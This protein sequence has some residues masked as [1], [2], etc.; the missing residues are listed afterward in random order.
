MVVDWR[1]ISWRKRLGSGEKA[2][3]KFGLPMVLLVVIGSVG[4]SEFTDIKIKRRDEKIRK[5]NYEESQTFYVKKKKKP[6]SLEEAYNEVRTIDIDEWENKRVP[7]PWTD[8]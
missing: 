4:L 5:M 3:L 6:L 7:R 1:W 2:F 8:N